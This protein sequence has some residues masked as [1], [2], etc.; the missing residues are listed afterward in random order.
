MP[1]TLRLTSGLVGTAAALALASGPG[2]DAQVPTSRSALQRPVTE[3]PSVLVASST[4]QA[5]LDRV[6]AMREARLGG[7]GFAPGEVLVKFRPGVSVAGQQRALTALR[8]RPTVGQFRWIGDVALLRDPS[9]PDARVLAAQLSEQPEVEFAEPNYLVQIAPQPAAHQVPLGVGAG[10]T[11]VPNDTSYGSRQWNFTA[12]GLPEAWDINPGAD[13][14]IVVAVVDSGV[15]TV[16]QTYQLP[17]WTGQGFETVT[18]PV[19]VN[20]D[21]EASRLTSPLD[22]TFGVTP[23]A[24][25]DMDGHGTHVAATIAE[26]TNNMLALAGIAYQAR[27]MPVKVCSGYW[28]VMFAFAR[29]GLPGFADEDEGGCFFSD[30]AAGI[31]Y[32]ADNG[33]DV[34][35][36]SLGGSFPSET[37]RGALLHAVGRGTFVAISAGNEFDEGNPTSYPAYYANEIDGVMAVA[38]LGRSMRRSFF[39]STGAYVEIAAPGG[40]IREGG[41]SGL[42]YQSSLDLAAVDPSLTVP[43]FDRYVETGFQGTSMAAPHVAG[44][45]ALIMSQMPGVRPAIVERII[46]LT[47]RP[48]STSSC[49]PGSGSGSGRTVEFGFGLV[50]PR[51]ALF[52]RGVR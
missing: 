43:R 42:I 15:T 8:S 34:I 7:L 45:A 24:V 39:S 31:R 38:A 22:L 5:T 19:G 52:G 11:A 37:V 16:N 14:S 10:P 9:Q 29:V 6:A 4:M 21:L 3:G 33:A 46:R 20:T 41:L 2:V 30:I 1:L 49:A 12:I 25:V 13:P 17:L 48:C 28:D 32:A 36:I 44:V 18:V 27:L 23:G 35:N 50:Q 26:N 51:A 40:D 47:A